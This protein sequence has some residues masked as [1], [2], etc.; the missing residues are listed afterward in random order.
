MARVPVS[1][2]TCRPG[3][4][5]AWSDAVSGLVVPSW[6]FGVN[7]SN[8]VLVLAAILYTALLLATI[9]ARAHDRT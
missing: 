4:C 8:L 6:R 5:G 2:I 3:A 9:A 7:D 1:G